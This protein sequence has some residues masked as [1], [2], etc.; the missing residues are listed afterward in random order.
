MQADEQDGRVAFEGVLGAIAVM[1]IPVDDRDP[2]H[3]AL[4][5]GIGCAYGH[6]IKEAKAHG[7]VAL[8]MVP[9]R[10]HGAGS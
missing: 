2:V 1:H 7:P 8:G 10:A 9:G 5:A 3:P 6:V 4:T